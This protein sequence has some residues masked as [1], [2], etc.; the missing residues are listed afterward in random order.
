MTNCRAIFQYPLSVAA[1]VAA[2]SSAGPALAQ[3]GGPKIG[4]D[5]ATG[6]AAEDA[7]IVGSA[8][9]L[10]F[11]DVSVVPM[12]RQT[13]AARDVSLEQPDLTLTTI[14]VLTGVTALGFVQRRTP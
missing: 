14:A 13:E 10:P 12:Q 11:A 5:L 6:S 1:C 3:T 8:M 4:P 9:F 7:S 2:L